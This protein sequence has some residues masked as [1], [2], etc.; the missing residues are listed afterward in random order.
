MAAA[1]TL[2]RIRVTGGPYKLVELVPGLSSL[3]VKEAVALAVSL[4]VGSFGIKSDA[5]GRV[6]TFHSGL[7]GNWTAV[8][9]PA[10]A[11]APSAL[12]ECSGVMWHPSGR[13]HAFSP[14]LNC[15]A[16]DALRVTAPV[17]PSAECRVQAT[18]WTDPT[19]RRGF[20][21]ASAGGIAAFAAAVRGEFPELGENDMSVYLLL[22]GSMWASRIRIASDS[23]LVSAL[24]TI[25]SSYSASPMSGKQPTL[26]IYNDGTS[27]TTSPGKAA[28]T[29]ASSPPS[30]SLSSESTTTSRSRQRQSAMRECVLWRDKH[31]CVFCGEVQLQ[32][33]HCAHIVGH[34]FHR[35][36]AVLA[37]VHLFNTFDAINGITLCIQCHGAF[38]SGLVCIDKST[39]KLLLA[40]SVVLSSM[41][42]FTG[43]WRTMGGSPVCLRRQRDHDSTA[44]SGYWPTAEIIAFQYSQFTKFIHTGTSASS[45]FA[46]ASK[47]D[48]GTR[49][50]TGAPLASNESQARSVSRGLT[51]AGNPR[52]L[53]SLPTSHQA[54]A[55]AAIAALNNLRVSKASAHAGVPPAVIRST[56]SGYLRYSLRVPAQASASST[57]P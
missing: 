11:A 36:R 56:A 55:T 25:T 46:T 2:L 30:G 4:P 27:P 20:S 9:L 33:L 43:K 17:H 41:L 31:T 8:A 6:A 13:R 5:D 29:L 37:S 44:G 3:D 53:Q 45:R 26:Y 19:I 42:H 14:L 40:D 16:G 54:T 7:T 50:G 15:P 48:T 35:N 28:L 32:H 23:G 21:W 49:S 1:P 24:Q 47:L 57:A 38:D 51:V 34:K 18:Y 12:G 10:L 39:Y 52:S 22:P